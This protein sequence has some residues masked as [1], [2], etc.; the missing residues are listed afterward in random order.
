MIAGSFGMP[1]LIL[2]LSSICQVK[3]DQFV[4]IAF[5]LV[6]LVNTIF[7]MNIVGSTNEA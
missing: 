1:L 6:A 4:V 2:G 7:A 3:F 5:A